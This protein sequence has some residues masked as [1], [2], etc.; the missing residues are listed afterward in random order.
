MYITMY[1][2]GVALLC[3]AQENHE[4]GRNWSSKQST[5]ADTSN[6]RCKSGRNWGL[7]RSL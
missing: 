6:L 2:G 7:E 3:Q 5:V 1:G 4:K